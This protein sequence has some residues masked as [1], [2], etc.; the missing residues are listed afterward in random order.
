MGP[1]DLREARIIFQNAL[2]HATNI[3]IHNASLDKKKVSVEEVV[4]TAKTIAREVLKLG[5]ENK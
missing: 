5:R 3:H 2:S 1:Q 4:E